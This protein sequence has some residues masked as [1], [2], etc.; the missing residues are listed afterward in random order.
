[1]WNQKN[2]YKMEAGSSK[3]EVKRCDDR[4][5][6]LLWCKKEVRSRG[7][8]EASR[9]QGNRLLHRVTKRSQP[10]QGLNHS[11]VKLWFQN[12]REWICVVL[13]HKMC[14]NLLHWSY[15][16]NICNLFCIKIYFF[17]LVFLKNTLFSLIHLFLFLSLLSFTSYF[18]WFSLSLFHPS[19]IQLLYH[20]LFFVLINKVILKY[21][22]PFKKRFC[23]IP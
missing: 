7:V 14:S 20:L 10:C 12:L 13:K 2:P 11:S 5:K 19:L 9:K 21:E 23:P 15:K 18:L 16:T 17:F 6:R 22:S 4:S 3:E 8:Q 1:M